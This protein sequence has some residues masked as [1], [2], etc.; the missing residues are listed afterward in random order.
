MATALRPRLGFDRYVKEIARQAALLCDHL[1]GAD[2]G[3][4]VPTCPGWNLAQLTQHVGEELRW[5][6]RLVGTRATGPIDETA[7]R[8]LSPV[9]TR[10]A[11]TTG[12]WIVEGADGL[13]ATLRAAGP[14]APVWT[15]LPHGRVVFFARRFA[16]EGLMHR[17]DAALALGV[18]FD[19]EPDL[20]V[21]ALAEWMELGAQP[22]MFAFH[23]ERRGLLGPGRMLRITA[24]DVDSPD[25]TWLVDLTGELMEHRPGTDEPAAAEAR[26]P[27][28]DVVLALYRRAAAD[29]LDVSGDHAL[30][31]RWV[32]L[33]SFA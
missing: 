27:V 12:A 28:R 26:G 21:D 29:T 11:G 17:V 30:F 19:V 10:G 5:L 7:M 14:D 32:E 22:E 4:P 6:D 9:P 3:R 15:P 23:P 25:A 24:T 20:A 13:V 1:A 18:P 8:E 2:L 16:H 31:E 33:S